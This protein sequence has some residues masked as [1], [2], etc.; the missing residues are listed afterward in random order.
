MRKKKMSKKEL[1]QM[2]GIPTT[3]ASLEVDVSADTAEALKDRG[4]NS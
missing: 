3:R 4:S 2:H 1:T